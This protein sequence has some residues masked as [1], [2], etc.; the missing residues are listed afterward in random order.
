MER[1]RSSQSARNGSSA[2]RTSSTTSAPAWPRETARRASTSGSTHGAFSLEQSLEYIDEV[3]GDY[4]AYG[5]L[6]DGELAGASVLELGPGDNFGVALRFLA[7]G[8]ER[9]VAM[10]KFAS[11]RDPAQ[12]RQIYEA[13][14][15]GSHARSGSASRRRST[16]TA[17]LRPGRLRAIEGVAVEEAATALAGERFDLIVSRAVLEHLYDLDAAFAAM[18]DAARNR[19]ERCSTRSTS[20]TTACSPTAACTR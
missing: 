12:Q 4:L 15:D 13:L 20:A 18:D 11:V 5:D 7:A 16:S 6:G 14:L 2:R 1:L 9:V 19:A 3:F 17:A 10:D 8:A